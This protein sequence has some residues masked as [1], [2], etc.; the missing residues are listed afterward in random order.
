M[1]RGRGRG[2][3]GENIQGVMHLTHELYPH[4]PGDYDVG[5][6]L[7]QGGSDV[8]QEPA[9]GEGIQQEDQGKI[10]G[11]KSMKFLSVS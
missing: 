8:N 7:S 3:G 9:S 5:E 10:T 4:Q 11:R 6:N 2:D 1:D